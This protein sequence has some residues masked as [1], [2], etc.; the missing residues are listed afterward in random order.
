MVA[1]DFS[2]LADRFGSPRP[3]RG[4]PRNDHDAGLL[5]ASALVT[6]ERDRECQ[7]QLIVFAGFLQGLVRQQCVKASAS[8]QRRHEFGWEKH[9]HGMATF[10]KL[11]HVN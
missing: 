2:W 9:W 5:F 10:S 1:L 11:D 7:S 4:S 8:I 6:M 3:K